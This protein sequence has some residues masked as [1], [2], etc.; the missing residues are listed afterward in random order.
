M[1]IAFNT[2]VVILLSFHLACVAYYL[3]HV[4]SERELF[5]ASSRIGVAATHSAAAAV[6][7]V[8]LPSFLP[9]ARLRTTM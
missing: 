8:G 2:V 7:W 4:R 3:V 5:P 6:V 9:S 1:V